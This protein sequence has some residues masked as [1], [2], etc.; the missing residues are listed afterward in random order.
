MI[1]D[2]G[3]IQIRHKSRQVITLSLQNFAHH[4]SPYHHAQR[5]KRHL[6]AV[7]VRVS[8]FFRLQHPVVI[9][10]LHCVVERIDRLSNQQAISIVGAGIDTA[11]GIFS[12]S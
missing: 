12:L 2:R 1:L 6:S 7:A 8:D 5:I 11:K 3:L 9:A 4:G 10:D